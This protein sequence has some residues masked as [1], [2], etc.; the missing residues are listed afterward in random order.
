LM[1]ATLIRTGKMQT[2]SRCSN[3]SNLCKDPQFKDFS[4][5]TTMMSLQHM[6]KSG[7]NVSQQRLPRC[8]LM[9]SQQRREVV[10]SLSHSANE[11]F[12]AS[13]VALRAE[14]TLATWTRTIPQKRMFPQQRVRRD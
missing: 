3:R 14:S 2:Q 11:P 12:P 9:N 7:R 4:R 10:H 1:S 6:L 8:P 5:T 13:K